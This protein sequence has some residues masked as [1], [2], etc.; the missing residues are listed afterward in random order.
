M[1]AVPAYDIELDE[2]SMALSYVT[3]A[4]GKAAAAPATPAPVKKEKKKE[5]PKK[6]S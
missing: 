1:A 5:A 4:L 2:L 3:M 6:V